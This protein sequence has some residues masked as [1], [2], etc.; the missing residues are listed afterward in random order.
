MN[1]LND[2]WL[3]HTAYIRSDLVYIKFCCRIFVFVM[4]VV[5]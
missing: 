2:G 5:P 1:K 3:L 4:D